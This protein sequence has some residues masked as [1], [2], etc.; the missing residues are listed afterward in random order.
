MPDTT[1]STTDIFGC[2]KTAHGSSEIVCSTGVLVA[3]QGEIM[4]A[5]SCNLNYQRQAQPVYELG[6]EDIWV[7]SQPASGSC[8]VGRA[9]SES[10]NVYAHINKDSC[11][12]VTIT[13]QAG[14]GNCTAKV[15]TVTATGCVCQSVG[16]QAQAGPGFL[17]ES[18]S[19]FVGG[20]YAS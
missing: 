16:L 20:V 11:R 19:W 4:L 17:T 7:T 8:E 13:L 1:Q 14:D 15:K 5:Q 2:T 10:K 18:M 12:G 9:V 6:H 3:I